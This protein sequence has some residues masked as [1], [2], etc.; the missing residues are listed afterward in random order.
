MISGEWFNTYN[1]LRYR[2]VVII[3]NNVFVRD[4]KGAIAYEDVD[5]FKRDYQTIRLENE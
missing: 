4:Y 2:V 5:I 3:N 1:G